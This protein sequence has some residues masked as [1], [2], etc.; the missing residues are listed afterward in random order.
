VRPDALNAPMYGHRA[1][2]GYTSPLACTEVFPY[3]FYRMVPRGITLV[4]T[5]LAIVDLTPA[6]LETS[7]ENSVLAAAD[8][9]SIGV[10]LVVLG[11]VPINLLRGFD[12]VEPLMRETAERIGVPVTSSVTAQQEAF[13][14]TKARR[15]GIVQPFPPS[16]EHWLLD[17]ADRFELEVA[18]IRSMGKGGREIGSIPVGACVEYAR[19][20]VREHPD[21]DTMWLPAP[22]YA[23]VEGI[24]AIERDLGVTVVS[25]NQAIAWHALR[26]CGVRDPISGFGRL[27]EEF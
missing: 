6:E 18:A 12:N 3:E 25:A 9:A 15:V 4:L 2:I 5:T 19:E 13:R 8:M 1:R 27:F 24:D 7:Y 20:I 22:H 14:A 21:I 26:R 17:L 11:G 23:T 10:D 16:G